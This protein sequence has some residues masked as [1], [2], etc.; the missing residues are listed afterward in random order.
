MSP[1]NEPIIR[2]LWEVRPDRGSVKGITSFPFV[3]FQLP[4]DR[5]LAVLD[6][7]DLHLGPHSDPVSYR[8]L[9]VIGFPLTSRV[10]NTLAQIGFTH[11]VE[12]KEGFVAT[13]NKEEASRLRV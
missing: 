3:A 8:E 4:E 11:F 13:R 7:F 12:G 5:F 6:D 9:E 2:A 10:R 1:V